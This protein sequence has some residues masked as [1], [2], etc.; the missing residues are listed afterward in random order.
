M[1]MW[2]KLAATFS[3]YGAN[4]G[5]HWVTLASYMDVLPRFPFI[6]S[7]AL[8][9]CVQLSGCGSQQAA[10]KALQ[11]G[12]V[13]AVDFS[14]SWELDYAQSDN[15]QAEF[16]SLVRDV[17]RQAERRQGNMH[18]GAGGS[19]VIGSGAN[20]GESVV[21][22]A[23]MADMITQSPLLEVEQGE[24]DIKVK[25]EENFALRCQFHQGQLQT[26]ETPFGTETCGWNGHQLV[27]RVVLP[28]GLSIQ[29][30]MTRGASGEK[31][32]IATTVVSDQV[33]Y[34]FTLNRVYNRFEP[35]S[36][37]FRCIMTLTRGRVCT[38]ESR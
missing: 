33:S 32:N 14:G 31:L 22:L 18:Q 21:G 36:G 20:S 13:Q 2:W 29:H 28:D 3:P 30:V 7:M 34:P 9:T 37:G 16:G 17:R 38:T 19:L 23:R 6:F 10:P 15:I 4:P 35:G 8:L 26:V 1:R 24:H 25:R 12:N 27:F 5:Q 11:G